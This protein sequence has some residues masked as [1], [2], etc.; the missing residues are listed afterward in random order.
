MFL[1][2]LRDAMRQGPRVLE[3]V[4]N[5]GF[6]GACSALRGFTVCLRLRVKTAWCLEDKKTE[7]A[8]TISLLVI[9]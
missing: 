1:M 3:H 5:Q 4:D 2:F 8:I 6:E 9:C 7:N